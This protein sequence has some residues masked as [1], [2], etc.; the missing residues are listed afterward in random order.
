M[1]SVL[2]IGHSYV[3]RM[4]RNGM[5]LQL[6]ESRASIV[7]CGY[8]DNRPLNTLEQLWN[9]F[10]WVINN[11]EI[12]DVV[13]IL[14]GSNDLCER[15]RPVDYSCQI[16]AIAQEFRSQGTKHVLFPE[17][18]PRYGLNAFRPCPQFLSRF[19][20]VSAKQAERI[21]MA[22]VLLYNRY[23]RLAC[24]VNGFQFVKLRGL[25]HA[26]RGQLEDG[27]HLSVQGRR[28]LRASL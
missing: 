16:V 25:H 12:P 21:Y 10:D 13:V 23:V 9:N 8:I 27:I 4:I 6:D 19:A 14:L 26:L 15:L 20:I 5:D 18:L 2:I 3:R 28:K 1:K 17:V 7:Y 22:R 24:V 11:Y